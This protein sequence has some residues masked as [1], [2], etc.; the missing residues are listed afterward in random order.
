MPQRDERLKNSDTKRPLGLERDLP[1]P[2]YHQLKTVLLEKLRGGEWK[3]ND[4]LPTEDELGSQF[5]VSKATV[6]QALR[7]LAQS[8]YVRREQGRGTFVSEQKVQF[9][10]RQLNS[11]T[12]EMRQVGLQS[13]SKVLERSVVAADAELAAKLQI[14]EGAEVF[15]L[16]RLRLAGGE[17]M[18]V[19]TV[20]VPYAM[21]PGLRDIDFGSA[22]LYDTLEQLFGLPLDYAAQTHFA[23]A[24][25]AEDAELLDVPEGSPALGG[26]RITYL[27]GGRPMEV[28]RSVM[29]GDR[30]QIHLKLVRSPAR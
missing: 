25:S 4:Q 2:L 19:Q 8:G 12:E 13:E 27:R 11:F 22:S 6:R 24:V 30:Y 23:I 10:P 15:K 14:A 21:V 7:D 29:K 9:G 18:G 3:P 17:T 16:K 28:T 1:V 20:Y 5:G 26:E